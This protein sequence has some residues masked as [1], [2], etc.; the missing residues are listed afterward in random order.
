MTQSPTSTTRVLLA[1]RP[2]GAPVS[3]DFRIVEEPLVPLTDGQLRVRG[4]WLSLDPY[5]RGRMSDAKS[6]V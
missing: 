5:M 2:T 4:H 1:R 3:E 6:Y